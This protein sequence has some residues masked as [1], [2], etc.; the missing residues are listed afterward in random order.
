MPAR[1]LPGRLRPIRMPGVADHRHR[2]QPAAKIVG[3]PDCAHGFQLKVSLHF[4]LSRRW[5][6]ATRPARIAPNRARQT[7]PP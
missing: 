6:R 3:P 5:C 2:E 1:A 7:P 4:D